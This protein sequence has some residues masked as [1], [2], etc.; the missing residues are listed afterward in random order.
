MS[1]QTA[2]LPVIQSASIVMPT[3][4]KMLKA[5][6]EYFK[7]DPPNFAAIYDRIF[8]YPL[9]YKQAETAVSDVTAGGIVMPEQAQAVLTSQRGL[10]MRAGPKAIEQL[11][12]HGV[13]LG[14]IIVTARFSPYERTYMANGR[15]HTMLLLRASEVLGSEDL[16]V[17]Y[18]KGDL[19]AE[20]APDGRVSLADRERGP[21]ER[22]DPED[23]IE[24]I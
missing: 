7:I 20:M 18:D 2:T 16:Q 23:N 1:S 5:R 19:W 13:A 17:A 6:L 11:H 12:A 4:P 10:L 14:H 21:R 9:D 22:T 15:V 8:V 24:G 3:L